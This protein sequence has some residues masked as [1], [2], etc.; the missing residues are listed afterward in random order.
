MQSEGKRV[1][2]MKENVTNDPSK[3]TPNGDSTMTDPELFDVAYWDKKCV[4]AEKEIRNI[5]DNNLESRS[6]NVDVA[7]WNIDDVAVWIQ[8]LGLGRYQ[9]E[10]EENEICGKRLLRITSDELQRMISQ[11]QDIEFIVGRLNKLRMCWKYRFIKL[12]KK[13]EAEKKRESEKISN[14]FAPN[15][16]QQR[17]GGLFKRISTMFNNSSSP[18][19]KDSKYQK[20]AAP[21]KRM[22]FAQNFKKN[23]GINTRSQ[24]SSDLKQMNVF[25]KRMS[26]N[27]NLNN[28][29][30]FELRT[31]R[32]SSNIPFDS[33]DDDLPHFD[34]D[35]LVIIDKEV[36]I[37]YILRMKFQIFVSTS[38]N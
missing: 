35:N 34:E 23:I 19:T 15:P 36:F 24:Y 14:I 3:E 29:K 6:L 2:S 28:K 8:S 13:R 16:D 12:R 4:F 30:D 9:A 38:G 7:K 22:S 27:Q 18:K 21:Q 33:M 37:L 1:K 25:I 31:I 20:S 32:T 17:M 5:I 26:F 11:K 10:F